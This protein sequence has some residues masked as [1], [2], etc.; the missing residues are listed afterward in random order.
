[1][2]TLDKEK[3]LM[4]CVKATNHP[5]YVGQI[6]NGRFRRACRVWLRGQFEYTELTNLHKILYGV[7]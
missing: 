2:I 5:H 7:K 3:K 6:C 4:L 1:M